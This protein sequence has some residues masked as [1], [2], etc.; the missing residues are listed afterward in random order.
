MK[1]Y[2]PLKAISQQLKYNEMIRPAIKYS[3]E[4]KQMQKDNFIRRFSATKAGYFPDPKM[5]KTNFFKEIMYR[6]SDFFYFD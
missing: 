2:N 5:K 3:K 1:I 4:L 6:I